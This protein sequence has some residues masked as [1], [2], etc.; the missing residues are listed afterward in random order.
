MPLREQVVQLFET[1]WG[2]Q[3]DS[4][5]ASP[6][7][8]NIIGEHTDYNN[9]FCFPMALP[10]ATYIAYRKRDDDVVRLISGSGQP[11]EGT[12]S[13]IKPGATLGWV[14]YAAGPAYFLGITHG[15]DA[16]YVSDV[17]LGAGL[18]SS[19]AIECA[20]ALALAPETD[21]R[22][23]VRAAMAAENEIAGA[24]TGGMDQATSLL[25]DEGHAILLDCQDFSVTQIPF[26]LEEAGLALLVMNTH[27]SHE[28]SDGQYGKRRAACEEAAA[29][30]GV[31]SLRQ[32]TTLEGL[33]GEP[34]K[35]AR[36]ILSENQRVLDVAA[37]AQE[38]RFEEIGPLLSESHVS[39]R[40]DFEISCLELDNVVGAAMEAGAL[41]ARMTGGGFGGSAIALVKA[42]DAE[43][44]AT[45]VEE[46]SNN[47]VTPTIMVVTPSKSGRRIA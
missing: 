6:G 47:P 40:D 46:N 19:A 24:P 37:L 9:G 26:D 4:I 16:A 10:Q 34:L 11:W 43:R 38:G 14:A 27:A 29:T 35:R 30:L 7:R 32:A 28:L 8:V 18:S 36:H 44:I 42:E 5:W 41:G 13:D 21:R 1:T 33:E 15:F 45:Y 23:L 22:T 31:D 39:M 20:T 12:I 17:P 3:P 25:S 2:G